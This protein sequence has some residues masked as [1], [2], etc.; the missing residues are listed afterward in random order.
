[1]AWIESHTALV[2]HRKTLAL[3][4]ELRLKPVYVVGH[5]TALWHSALEQQED[6]DLSSW[7]D[8]FIADAAHYTGDCVKFVTALRQHRWLDGHLLHDWLDYSGLY[9]TRKYTS[10]NKDRLREIWLKYGRTYGSG[11]ARPPDKVTQPVTTPVT[12]ELQQLLAPNL[13]NLPN[14]PTKDGFAGPPEANDAGTLAVRFLFYRKG[15]RSRGEQDSV[16]EYFEELLRLGHSVGFLTAEVDRPDRARSESAWDFA[17]RVGK[18]RPQKP[19]VDLTD[20]NVRERIAREELES[21]ERGN[22]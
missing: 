11:K 4:K 13:P 2:R 15:Y 17:D 6:G 19:K 22:R 5:L 9:L 1:M 16:I 8:D 7:T 3:A 21:I 12:H 10:R 18:I 14:L 20:P